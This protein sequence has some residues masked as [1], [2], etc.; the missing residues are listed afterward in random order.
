MKAWLVVLAMGVAPLAQAT[1]WVKIG[2][3]GDAEHFV[4]RESLQRD[5]EVVRLQKRSVFLT[6]RPMGDTPGMPMMGEMLGVVEDDCVR[7]QHRAVSFRIVGV[8]GAEL[9]ASGDMKR[10]WE[11]APAGT[12]GRA[13]LDYACAQTAR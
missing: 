12:A 10:V 1:D 7:L 13:T 4:D 6:P 8:D 9:W 5:G 2:A 3:D 11:S